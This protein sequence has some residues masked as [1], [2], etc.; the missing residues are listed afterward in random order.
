MGLPAEVTLWFKR[1]ISEKA[2]WRPY[3]VEELVYI[4]GWIVYE[5]E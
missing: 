3:F 5:E 1:S 2:A 4:H